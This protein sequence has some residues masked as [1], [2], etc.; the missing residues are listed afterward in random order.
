MDTTT[1]SKASRTNPD[2]QPGIA[3]IGCG[4]GGVAMGIALKRAGIHSF[5]IYERASDVGGVWRDNTYPGAAC[6]IPSLWYCYSFE[7]D[8]AWSAHYAP[9]AEIHA[10]IK[11]C[12]DKY[13]LRPHVRLNTEIEAAEFDAATATWRLTTT[14][15]ETIEAKFLLTAVGQFNRPALPK[16]PGLESFKGPQFHSSRWN[17][18]F[19]FTGKNVAVIGVGASGLQIVPS[20]APL[21]DKLY[22]FQR[23]PQFVFPRFKL[24]TLPKDRNWLSRRLGRFHAYYLF[25]WGT[26]S[27]FMERRRR[28]REENYK[29]FL[30]DIVADPPLLEKLTPD[31]PWTCKRSL[32]SDEWY[33]TLK[34]SNVELVVTPITHVQPTGIR[35]DDGR[36][37]DV[38][39]IILATGFTVTDF[40]AP[41]R[42]S[43]LDGRNLHQIWRG[44]AE[45]YLGTAIAGFPNLFMLYGPN[46]GIGGSIIYM[47]EGQA[48]YIV[49]CIKCLRRRKARYMTVRED[50]QREF[51][52]LVQGRFNNTVLA[53]EDCRTYFKTETGRITTQW[54]GFMAEL[55]MRLLKLRPGDYEFASRNGAAGSPH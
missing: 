23:S 22:V 39:A 28:R 4:F 51:N 40:L 47:L 2:D 17:H 26:I 33:G 27:R 9:Q 49:Q 13:G 34:R 6:D 21:V 31:Y 41:M 46:A 50:V 19:D 25:E 12:V 48:K 10:Y 36:E 54:P 20:I 11:H 16:I 44:D 30:K 42:I 14:D 18:D 29:Q 38:D 55:R 24:G 37:M 1:T 43:G 35:T 52:E 53:G 3:I 32:F 8:F 15:Q 7:Q 45:A 5:T